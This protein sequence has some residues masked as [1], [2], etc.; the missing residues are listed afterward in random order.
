LE[1]DYLVTRVSPSEIPEYLNA[2]DVAISFVKSSFSTLSRSPTKIPEYLA[3]G[4]PIIANAGVGDV[5]ALI[6]D[7]SVGRLIDGFTDNDY[8]IALDT[9]DSLGEDGDRCREIARCKFDLTAVGGESYRRLYRNL[10]S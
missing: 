9:I 5:D 8:L 4:L 6:S 3:C 1:S 10:L 7:N 2:S